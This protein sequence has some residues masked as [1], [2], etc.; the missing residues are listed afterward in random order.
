MDG[1]LAVLADPTR[2][3][4]IE[5]LAE[6]ERS[7]GELVAAFPVSQPAVS[8]HLRVLREAGLARVR[9][10][11]QR[12]IYRLDPA[13]LAALDDWL[14]RYRHFWSARLDALEAR[15]AERRREAA[16]EGATDDAER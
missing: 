11:G 2:R 12:R 15:L 16:E 6:R 5:L 13:P 3:E 8:R 7:A 10:E 1:Q 9:G 14:G 4:I